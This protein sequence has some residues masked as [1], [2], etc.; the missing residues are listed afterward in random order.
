MKKPAIPTLITAD[1]V[2]KMLGHMATL[3]VANFK[4]AAARR[5]A[6]VSELRRHVKALE[7]KQRGTAAAPW[8]NEK[9]IQRDAQVRAKKLQRAKKL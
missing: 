4:Q 9:S 5:D 2:K 6:E 3:I 8:F 1:A 7:S